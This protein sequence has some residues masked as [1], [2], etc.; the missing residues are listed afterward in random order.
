[1]ETL[2]FSSS[3]S[4]FSD[5]RVRRILHHYFLVLNRKPFLQKIQYLTQE[6]L[7]L[8]P[9]LQTVSGS[10][11]SSWPVVTKV[12][13]LEM[14]RPEYGT[15]NSFPSIFSYL[16]SQYGPCYSMQE[17]THEPNFFNGANTVS[18]HKSGD[19]ATKHCRLYC[20]I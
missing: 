14:K 8:S 5:C 1:M 3:V 15:E 20:E 6:E 11:P 2:F 19:A 9:L 10:N 17:H 18:H 16:L 12:V 7:F 4:S 13:S